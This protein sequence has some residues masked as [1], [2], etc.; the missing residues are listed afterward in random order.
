MQQKQAKEEGVSDDK[1]LFVQF[2]KFPEKL[3][4]VR[5]YQSIRAF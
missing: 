1:E 2:V 3:I 5:D 4:C